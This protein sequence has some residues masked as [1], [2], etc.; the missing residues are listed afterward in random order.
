MIFFLTKI[1]CYEQ[2]LKDKIVLY[3]ILFIVV[4]VLQWLVYHLFI[5]EID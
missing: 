5:L 1:M 2:K 4:I 3:V